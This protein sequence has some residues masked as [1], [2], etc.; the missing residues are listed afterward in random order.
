MVLLEGAANGFGIE[1]Q[2]PGD[3]LFV[4]FFHEVEVAYISPG[5]DIHAMTSCS[6]FR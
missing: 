2:L 3:G 1:V 5:L 4:E 6:F